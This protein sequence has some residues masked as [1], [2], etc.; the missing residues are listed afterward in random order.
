MCKRFPGDRREVNRFTAPAS[1]FSSDEIRVPMR[2]TRV[3]Y[4][5]PV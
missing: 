3:L 4:F 2:G 1:G 5:F